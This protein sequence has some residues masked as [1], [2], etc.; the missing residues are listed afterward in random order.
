MDET[1]LMNAANEAF[2]DGDYEAARDKYTQI[3]AS[4]TAN[5]AHV[6]C[7]R[8]SAAMQLAAHE[9]AAA[10]AR[11]ALRAA[12]DAALA[13]RVLADALLHLN[14]PHDA[15]QHA[16]AALTAANKQGTSQ[17]SLE[18]VHRRALAAVEAAGGG[19]AESAAAVAA[20]AVAAPGDAAASAAPAASPSPLEVR[21]EWYQNPTHV[22]FEWFVK[23]AL[24]K[25]DADVTFKADE[26]EC[27]S[28]TSPAVV[29]R[30]WRHHHFASY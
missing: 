12:P 24:R 8:A 15:L 10:D 13:H 17:A 16:V 22:T 25:S 5:A 3:L 20:A 26:V 27:N 7:K 30:V 29:V 28:S 11:A 18:Q 1:S 6:L 4:G 14:A 21:L 19:V 9:A 2:V 23:K